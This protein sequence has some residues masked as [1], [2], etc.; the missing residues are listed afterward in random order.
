MNE[1]DSGSVLVAGFDISYVV[2]SSSN[3]RSLE[4]CLAEELDGWRL[5][6]RVI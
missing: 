3:K 1:T 6:W 2:W 5:G 4:G